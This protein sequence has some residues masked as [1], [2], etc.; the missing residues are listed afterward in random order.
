MKKHR[1]LRLVSVI[2]LVVL[3]GCASKPARFYTLQSTVSASEGPGASYAVVVGPVTIPAAVDRPEMVVQLAPNQVEL[4][5]FDRWAAPLSDGI[6]RAVAGDLATLLGTPRVATAPFAN[7]VPDYRVT[8][9]LQRFDATPGEAVEVDAVWVVKQTTSGRAL[10]GRTIAREPV[11]G[12]GYDAVAAAHS[13]AL[14]RVSEDVATE[15]RA[16]ATNMR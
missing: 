5:E 13:R 7:F 1:S 3:A 14:A 2:C 15:I 4:L 12:D 11:Q 10:S 16:D 9:D 8:I 6:A